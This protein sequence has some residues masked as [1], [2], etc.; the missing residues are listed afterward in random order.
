MSLPNIQF[1]ELDARA[2][3][4]AVIAGYVAARKLTE[5]DFRLYAGNPVRLFLEAIAALIAQ[6]NVIID[7]TGKGN[8]LR[9]AGEGTIEDI[10]WLYGTRGDRIQAAAAKTTICYTLSAPLARATTIIKGSRVTPPS[11]KGLYF[12]TDADLTILAGETTGLVAAT[13]ETAG[14]IGNGYEPG[15]ISTIVERVNPY[16]LSAVNV[17]ASAGGAELEN[18]EAYRARVRL[19]PESF[20]VA[21]PDGAYAFW[22]KS[23]NAGIT[24]VGV[25][26][27][28]PGEV[29]VVPLMDGGELPAQEV[30]DAVYE[31]LND[32][33]RRPLTDLVHVIAPEPVTYEIELSYWIDQAE[34]ANATALQAAVD[35][36]VEEYRLW[37]RSRLGRDIIPSRLVELVMQ[38][39]ARRVAV[40]APVYTILDDGQV[41]QETAVTVNYGG[42][43]H[44]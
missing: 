15:E 27:P 2:I 29:N 42:L 36:A 32:K 26:S 33:T 35:A 37:Q 30:T 4:N 38:A 8:L 23:A 21:G 28:I 19:V 31:V 17:T 10:G 6:Q 5:P 39:G 34:A 9:Y 11:A 1:A 22:A 44:A 16:V 7:L 12:A 14:I 25:W 13:C 41:A 3:E 40:T 43:E 18:L 20:S 24:D